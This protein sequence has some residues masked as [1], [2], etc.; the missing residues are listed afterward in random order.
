M[1]FFD[2]NGRLQGMQRDLYEGGIRV[3]MIA[4]WPGHIQAGAVSQHIS[5]FQDMLPTLSQL[6]GAEAP[7]GDGLSMVPTL[8]GKG[9]QLQHDH[10]SWEFLEQ[11]GRRAVLQGHWKGVRQNTDNTPDGPIELYDI[12]KD[13]E[14]AYNIADQHLEVVA[15]LAAI[16][17]EAHSAP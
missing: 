8:L 14:E 6:A 3:P 13:I 12:S 9:D 16:M 2:S 11:G 10:L 7:A 4:R 5:G 15:K 1:P 17:R